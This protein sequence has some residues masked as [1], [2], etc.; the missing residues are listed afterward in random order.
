MATSAQI[1]EALARA[2]AAGNA[3]DVAQLQAALAS[4][5]G[6]PQAAPTQP[7][8][9]TRAQL[10]AA[11]YAAQAAGN[12]DD[13]HAAMQALR[14]RGMTL[15]P[16]TDE[17]RGAAF[18]KANAANVA[19]QP[20]YETALQGVGKSFVD[21][22]RGI[23]QLL[24]LESGQ[25]VA[26]ARNLDQALSN[27]TAGKVGNFVGQ[28][29]QA[30]VPIGGAE[31]AGARLLGLAGRALPIAASALGSG[32]FAGAQPV[33]DGES[34]A[35]N[36][37][38]GAVL[39]AAGGALPGALA[40]AAQKAAPLRTAIQQAA[41]DTADRFGIPL[42]LSQVTDSRFA[43]VLGSVANSLPFSGAGRAIRNQQNAFNEAV[44]GQFGT[45]AKTLTDDVFSDA[46]LALGKGYDTIF[47]RNNVAIDG[48]AQS[49]LASVL[50][51]ATQN[52]EPADAKIVG[53]Q[54][55]RYINA[56]RQNGGQIPGRLYQNIV[57]NVRNA[58]QAAANN[59]GRKAAINDVLGAMQ[60][61]S[62]RSANPGDAEALQLLNQRWNSMRIAEDAV[63]KRVAGG[64]GDV[65][66]ASLWRLVNGKYGSTRDMRDL[67]RLGQT[68][69]KNP[70]PDS[71]TAP[72][73]IAYGAL[74]GLGALNP[75]ALAH[76]L[77][78]AG[79]GAT[80]GRLM[81]S[82]T[83]ARVLPGATQR[84]LSALSGGSRV[85]PELLAPAAPVV[86]RQ[87]AGQ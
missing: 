67:A 34:R 72:R 85:A 44:S 76:M 28:A 53:N 54:I 80:V 20:W 38:G 71:G 49:D 3:D 77:P 24:G 21:T 7:S 68:V 64:G 23:G 60:G 1:Q 5:Q 25:N 50:H 26:D 41:M 65:Q 69:L 66:P 37:A 9:P 16:M 15:A 32:A 86:G 8:G 31:V 10:S 12:A 13:A 48:Q 52:L 47:G 6:S 78:I 59:P 27:S 55:M 87:L 29:A 36:A 57:R 2:Q 42:H 62:V 58:A 83:A 35:A 11:L 22:G 61:A 14:Q 33:A 63:Q 17:Q 19:A 46:R 73:L 43:K 79:A 51:D 45:P 40:A 84:F 82:A 56:A 18:Q 30:A 4:T 81:N 74:S 70:I 75:M 39:G